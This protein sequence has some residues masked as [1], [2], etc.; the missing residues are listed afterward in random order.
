MVKFRFGAFL[1][2][3]GKGGGFAPTVARN[4]RS[5]KDE[6]DKILVAGA[7]QAAQTSRETRMNRIKDKNSF[8]QKAKYLMSLG[9]NL[10]QAESVLAGG[11]DQADAF[12]T[13]LQ[14]DQV[15]ARASYIRQNNTTDGFDY[16][17]S[18][19]NGRNRNAFINYAFKS[20]EGA[21]KMPVQGRDLV[22]LATN[23]ANVNN[24]N[25]DDKVTT[26]QAGMSILGGFYGDAPQRYAEDKFAQ[27]YS[28]LGGQ[29]M[30][31]TVV[32][33]ETPYEFTLP[34]SD[35][36]LEA[37]V[38]GQLAT[39]ERTQVA[40]EGLKL[41]NVL[42]SSTL[43]DNIMVANFNMKRGQTALVN[44][45]MQTL[46][47]QLELKDK[48]MTDKFKTDKWYED[49]NTFTYQKALNESEIYD[50]NTQ[51]AMVS[52]KMAQIQAKY[53]DENNKFTGNITDA[54]D[55]SRYNK[56][57]SIHNGLL[58]MD[59]AYKQSSAKAQDTDKGKYFKTFTDMFH[60]NLSVN[61]NS[62][63]ILNGKV[64]YSEMIDTQG[65]SYF[66][67]TN[68]AS[69]QA[70]NADEIE[71]M[72][73][74]IAEITLQ[75]YNSTITTLEGFRS[76]GVPSAEQAMINAA[77]FANDAYYRFTGDL[78]DKLIE[79]Y[80]GSEDFLKP[81]KKIPPQAKTVPTFTFS[82]STKFNDASIQGT[83]DLF[84]S[85]QMDGDWA[86]TIPYLVSSQVDKGV[87][88]NI[89]EHITKDEFEY[90]PQ[91]ANAS[92][93]KFSQNL[94]SI[95]AGKLTQILSKMSTMDNGKF[96]QDILALKK[97]AEKRELG[98]NQFVNLLDIG[99]YNYGF[100]FTNQ[101][102]IE[103]K[104]LQLKIFNDALDLIRN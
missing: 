34:V 65:G 60:K 89:T 91:T 41:D 49:M 45:N 1:G 78:D 73:R 59:L 46:V 70:M 33:G 10:G 82:S 74:Q 68:I 56:L 87:I 2:G 76:M 14:N 18:G 90:T 32:A 100:S 51:L 3:D 42:K 84:N 5:Q 57:Q 24:P 50:P 20:R 48:R 11:L 47:N 92:P 64:A 69:D 6:L 29:Q 95:N 99:R 13:Q 52:T 26:L 12:A 104:Q 43:A 4:L 37:Q 85:S 30:D 62:S 39:V 54:S 40:I 83:I 53:T 97:K 25:L 79:T 71:E 88:R 75:V 103:I 94:I 19:F 31:G 23:Y 86:N 93:I 22:T 67:F 17:G 101:D 9:L 44:E 77:G 66:Q 102:S 38:A 81:I 15:A 61:I 7:Q 35:P 36:A 96:K 21:D 63:P 55:L 27:T 72:N 8:E 80:K 16:N 98:N 28:A 58:G